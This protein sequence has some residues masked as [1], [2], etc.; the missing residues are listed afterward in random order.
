MKQR[1]PTLLVL[2]LFLPS[3]AFAHTGI[4]QTAGF[5]HGLAHPIGGADHLL[6][7]LAVGIWAAQ[8]GGQA[9]WR[10][11]GTFVA[12]M[13]LG[14]LLGIANIPL[15]FIE[16]GILVSIVVLG[17]LITGAFKIRL[18]YSCLLVGVFAIFH[19]YTHGSEMPTSISAA[20]YALGFVM[21]TAV[22]HLSGIG[23][24]VLMKKT[25]VQMMGRFAGSTIALCGVYLA[26]QATFY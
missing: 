18:V 11:T 3:I 20:S 7:M 21:A 25:K 5:L 4:D 9:L 26:S 22:L 1:I 8:I 10:V 6:A 15:P 12:V 24:A 17:I 2:F 13:L 14:G 19:G 23:L 16:E